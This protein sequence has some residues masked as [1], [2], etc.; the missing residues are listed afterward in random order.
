[1]SYDISQN[2][3]LAYRKKARDEMAEI[4]LRKIDV[5]YN[6]HCVIREVYQGHI[7]GDIGGIDVT[8]PVFDLT[9]IWLGRR[10]T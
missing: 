8:I 3:F 9:Y 2:I 10:F 6:I 7:I 4:A 5:G 1:M